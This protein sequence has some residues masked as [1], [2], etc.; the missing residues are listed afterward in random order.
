MTTR[1]NTPDRTNPDGTRTITTKRACNG[2][3]QL[4]GDIT[5][6]EMNAAVDGRPLPDVRRECPTCAATAPP[7]ACMPATVVAGDILCLELD[8]DHEADE[9]EYCEQ[10]REEHI[11]NTHSTSVAAES[12]RDEITHA[13]PW[14]CQHNPSRLKTPAT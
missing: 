14:P 9:G 3:G 6:A 4:I 5:T 1:T 11:C 7:P 12:G 2:C 10:V 13:E 8:C